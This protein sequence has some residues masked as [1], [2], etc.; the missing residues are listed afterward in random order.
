MGN[1]SVLVANEPRSYREAIAFVFRALRPS[2]RVIEVEP[3]NLDR[4]VERLKPELVVCCNLTT[5]VA[6]LSPAWVILFPEG[7]PV[8]MICTAGELS[9]VTN[10]ELDNLL[11]V[12]DQVVD[13]SSSNYA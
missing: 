11:S 13:L 2:I 4:E 6:E 8:G 5:K 9:T 12:V 1:I 7:N 3:G 10:I